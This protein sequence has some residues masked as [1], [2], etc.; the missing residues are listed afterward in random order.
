[1]KARAEAG[2]LRSTR[3]HIRFRTQLVVAC[4]GLALVTGGTAAPAAAQ[5]SD[6]PATELWR[7]YP[8]QRP[9]AEK[10][11]RPQG[12]VQAA[13]RRPA[14]DSRKPERQARPAE[15][16]SEGGITLAVGLLVA[17]GFLLVAAALVVRHARQPVPALAG[18]FAR[19]VDLGIA[20][21]ARGPLAERKHVLPARKREQKEAERRRRDRAKAGK[22]KRQRLRGLHRRRRSRPHRTREAEGAV[23]PAAMSPVDLADEA[24]A[25]LFTRPGRTSLTILG[26]V[27]GLAALVATLGLSR[28]ANNRIATHFDE[29]AATEVHV[30]TR[31]A[32]QNAPP[33][34]IPWDAPMRL[35][36]LNGVVAAGNLSTVDVGDAL[37]TT[38]PVSDPQ[39]RTDLKLAV[40]AASLELFRAVRADLSTGR[41]PDEGHSRRGERVAVLGRQAADRLGIYGLEHL[42][43]I[44]IGDEIFLV[45]GI[46]DTVAR[47]HD[48]LAAVIVPE[49]T[50]RRLYRLASP[51]FVVVET[52]L[53]ATRLIAKQVP[54]ALAPHNP[55][56][57]KVTFAPEERRVREAVER[58]LTLLFLT[59]GGVSLVVGAIGIANVT[60]VS[61]MERTGEIGLRR[62][63]GATRRHIALQ[64]LLESSAM[65]VVGG[66]LGASL[67]T[68]VVVVVSAYESWTPVLDPLAPL[69][70]PLVGG[71]T[72]LLAG[73]YPAMR[74]ARMEPVEA[75]RTA[76]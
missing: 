40:Q 28:T 36:R 14:T 59:L 30:T 43:A 25:G 50:A 24:V 68:L 56:G 5:R 57:L 74:A 64:F 60:L 1:V 23:Q 54:L 6:R 13:F 63:L 39:R 75:L 52:R 2:G 38:S 69:A 9:G 7:E 42:P 8:L 48:L 53:G 22:W 10:V 31:P 76:T 33:H 4:A 51:E 19:F 45:I 67:G 41:L 66:V 73:S 72:G 27:I 35:E 21:A 3:A 18:G 37:V 29:V 11:P 58:D 34:R 16:D 12:E 65:G 26:T 71:L 47:Q 20:W 55:E 61:V 32:P 17:I 15:P 49:G 62:A 70:A 46:L 44:S